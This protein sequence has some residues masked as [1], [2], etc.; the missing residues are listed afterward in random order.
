MH[1]PDRLLSDC[2]NCIS[3]TASSRGGTGELPENYMK[4]GGPLSKILFLLVSTFQETKTIWR[5]YWQKR[6]EFMGGILQAILFQFSFLF[7]AF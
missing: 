3:V 1:L 4:F 5:I 7:Y 6:V 2:K